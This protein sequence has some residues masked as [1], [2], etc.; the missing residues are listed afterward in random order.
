MADW[1]VSC[2]VPGG[3]LMICPGGTSLISHGLNPAPAPM[4]G[5]HLNLASFCIVRVGVSEHSFL[6]MR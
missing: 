6:F 4:S 2:G 1:R 3:Y 5:V